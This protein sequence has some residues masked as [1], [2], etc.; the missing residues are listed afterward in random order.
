MDALYIA[1]P[2]VGIHTFQLVKVYFLMFHLNCSRY[3]AFEV[4]KRVAGMR[5]YLL[6]G[7]MVTIRPFWPQKWQQGLFEDLFEEED[8]RE[9]MVFEGASPT[10]FAARRFFLL[11]SFLR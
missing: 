9:G 5:P 10:F 11:F 4:Q 8:I 1:Y 2:D 7:K 3:G 6:L